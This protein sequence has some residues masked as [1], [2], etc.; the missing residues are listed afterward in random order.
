MYLVLLYNIWYWDAIKK[1]GGKIISEIDTVET[2]TWYGITKALTAVGIPYSI[3]DTI[4]DFIITWI[5]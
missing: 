5:L 3:A 1:Y 4:A 2:W